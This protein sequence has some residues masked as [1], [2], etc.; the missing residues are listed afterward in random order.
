[1][2]YIYLYI[3]VKEYNI[4]CPLCIASLYSLR[5]EVEIWHIFFLLLLSD[6]TT[7]ATEM[8]GL[9]NPPPSPGTV[10][11]NPETELNEAAH[12]FPGKYL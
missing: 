12:L 3:L 10:H 6:N 8:E 7:P 1:M 5:I 2:K 9:V 4:C 11:T